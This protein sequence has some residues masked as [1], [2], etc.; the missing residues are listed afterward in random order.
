MLFNSLAF[1]VFFPIVFIVYWVL[2]HKYRWIFLLAASYFFYMSWNV[3][4][5]LLIFFMTIMSYATA[6]IIEKTHDKK[7]KR[8]A[9]TLG[10]LIC[11]SLLIFFKYFNFLSNTVVDILSLFTIKLNP[12]TVSV[13]LPV[14]ISFYTFQ[15]LSY[16]IDVYRETAEAEHDFGIYAAFISFFPQLIAGPI[17]RTNNLLP[18]IR[19]EKQF[20][21]D[22]AMYGI[23][24]MLWGYFKKMAIADVLAVYVDTVYE[25]PTS[26]HGFDLL[27][28][29]FFFTIQ[30]YCDFSGYSDIAIGTAKMLGINLMTNFKSPY[31]SSSLREYWSRWHISL[32]TWFRDYVYIPMGG[33]RCSKARR[34]FNLFVTFLVSG[35]WHGASWTFAIWGGIHGIAQII[36]DSCSEKLNKIRNSRI[37]KVILTLIVFAFCNIAWIFFRAES[38]SDALYVITHMFDN[39]L[40]PSVYLQNSIGL[41][42]KEL[43]LILCLIG[44]AALYD[45]YSLK[46]DVMSTVNR[47]QKMIRILV[48]YILIIFMI[49]GLF[50][51]AGTNQFVYFQF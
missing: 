20:D 41:S 22:D 18:Q 50:D 28:V 36:E 3:K 34:Y 21:Y 51:S 16:M 7:R 24:L 15:A 17:E 42:E 32:S 33:N 2:P 26:Y 45:Y 10:I 9:L 23:R 25:S 47:W 31:F 11:L 1:A 38:V 37:G 46:E 14:G 6:L 48:G 27:I 40:S 13:L 35:M 12:I 4:Y 39:I 49:W 5:V 30:I 19:S 29:V 44:I 43:I 8:I